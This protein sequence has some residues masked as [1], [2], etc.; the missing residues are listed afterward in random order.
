MSRIPMNI[1][2]GIGSPRI[3][4]A[5]TGASAGLKKNTS[6]VSAAEVFSIERKYAQKPRPV[7][8]MYA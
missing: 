4:R 1:F 2:I 5:S 6:E 8:P 7:T 3:R